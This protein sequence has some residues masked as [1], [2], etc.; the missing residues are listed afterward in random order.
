MPVS[1]CQKSMWLSEISEVKLKSTG[2]KRVEKKRSKGS[3]RSRASRSKSP[4][5]DARGKKISSDAK[6]EISDQDS[7]IN[8]ADYVPVVKEAVIGE[9]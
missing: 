3:A 6:S 9:C 4:G 7:E 5:P 1:Q 8:A 2:N